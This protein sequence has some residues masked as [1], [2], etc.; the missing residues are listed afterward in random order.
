MADV[1][2][3]TETETQVARPTSGLSMRVVH[4][5]MKNASAASFDEVVK[6]I[7]PFLVNDAGTTM[8]AKTMSRLSA[9]AKLFGKTLPEGYA[10]GAA[11]AA[12][13]SAKQDAFIAKKEEARVAAEAQAIADAEA[14]VA[15]TSSMT[16]QQNIVLPW[17]CWT[18]H[19]SH[20][21]YSNSYQAAA[22]EA[23]AIEAA[24][25]EASLAPPDEETPPAEEV[26]AE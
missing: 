3:E 20:L 12:K 26:T 15:G 14:A 24:A 10:A 6:T 7:E 9:Q 13:R 19:P 22:A 8:L 4:R 11:A 25:V 23:A 18:P 2:A 1:E 5:M 21:S 17:P 16:Q